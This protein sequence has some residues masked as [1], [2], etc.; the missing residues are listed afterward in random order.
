[1]SEELLELLD[2]I[3]FRVGDGRLDRANREATVVDELVQSAAG[4]SVALK[5]LSSVDILLV[6]HYSDLIEPRVAVGAGVKLCKGELAV[7]AV[8]PGER[9]AVNAEDLGDRVSVILVP[10]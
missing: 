8:T 7:P 4:N 9:L 1:M 2:G 5:Y 3:E 6:S 10:I